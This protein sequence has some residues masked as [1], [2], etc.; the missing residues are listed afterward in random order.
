MPPE[1]IRSSTRKRSITSSCTTTQILR[2]IGGRLLPPARPGSLRGR[3]HTL[4]AERRL[5]H[6]G[7]PRRGRTTT[8][9]PARGSRRSGAERQRQLMLRRVIAL[10]VGVLLIILLLLA[11]RGCLNARKERGFENYVLGPGDDRRAVE[12]ALD[13]VLRPAREPRGERRPARARGPDRLRPRH[14]RGAA[15]AGRG[16][17]HA[18]RAR[19]RAG[20]ARAGVRAPPRRPRRD[21]RR[22]PD[23]ARQRGT[24]RGDRPDR[25][26]H[27]DVPGQRRA[28]R[29]GPRR[30]QRPCSP[31]RAS[32]TR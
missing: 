11:V 17:R 7:F 25:R 31:R 8:A 20:R 26:G 29:P 13:R 9:D 28:L 19:R 4:T 6:R 2:R 1:P 24:R 14:R 22:H 21:R 3:V 15:A 23:G 30:D 16:P 18:R 27:A 12:P 5:L 32:A 10:V